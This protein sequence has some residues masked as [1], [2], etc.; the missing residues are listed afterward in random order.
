MV[1]DSMKAGHEAYKVP[2][3][4]EKQLK[5]FGRLGGRFGI[6]HRVIVRWIA[7]LFSKWFCS[8]RDESLYRC[9]YTSLLPKTRLPTKEPMFSG[10]SNQ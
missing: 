3:K 5:D 9:T 10:T 4:G 2:E 7:I 1:Q 6:Y 8:R